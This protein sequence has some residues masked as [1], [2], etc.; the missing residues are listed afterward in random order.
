MSETE[1]NLKA[2]FA[3]ESQANRRYLAFSAQAE[4]EG[5]PNIAKLFKVAAES[6]TYHALGHLKAMSGVGSTEENLAEAKSGE[7]HEAVTM[8]PEFIQQAEAED[9]K[10]AARTFSWALAAEKV[11]EGLYAQALEALKA[12][13]D[14]E[15]KQ[16]YICPVCG[17]TMHGEVPDRCPICNAQKDRFIVI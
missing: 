17:Y 6:E 10:K 2:A 7:N 1:E 8:Y 12:G 9:N 16:Y 14:I 5:Y 15:E 13:N 3:G 4:K 11:H